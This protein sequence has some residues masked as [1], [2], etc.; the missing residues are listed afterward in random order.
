[1]GSTGKYVNVIACGNMWKC[2]YCGK[3]LADCPEDMK[4][5]S[6]GLTIGRTD[7]TREKLS[8]LKDICKLN[9]YDLFIDACAGSGK[10]QLLDGGIIDGSALV[11][12]N[13][14][15]KRTPQQRGSS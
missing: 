9:D 4:C 2:N 10:V 13:L 7:A 6:C 8:I 14:A 12:E 3:T 11:L 1:M 5:P 15:K